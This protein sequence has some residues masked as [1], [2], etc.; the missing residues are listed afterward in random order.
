MHDRMPVILEAEYWKRY[1]DAEPLSDDE[2]KAMITTS[3][4]GLLE[5]CPVA[6]KATGEELT[7][8]IKVTLSKV[9][10]PKPSPQGDLFG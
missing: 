7:R 10:E 3:P 6:N 4:A 5:F 1:L 8:E 2:R 9:E